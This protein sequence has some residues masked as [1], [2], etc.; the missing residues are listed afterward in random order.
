MMKK[1][2]FIC[3]VLGIIFV[4]F[5]MN[6]SAEAARTLRLA[7]LYPADFYVTQGYYRMAERIKAETNGE[8]EIQIFPANQLGSYEQAFEEVI[9][10]TIDMAGNYPTTRFNRRFEIGSFPG[11][12]KNFDEFRKMVSMDSPFSKLVKNVYEEAGCTYVGS[13]TAELMGAQIAKG[14]DIAEPFVARNKQRTVRVV[15]VASYRDFYR[16]MGYQITFVPYAEIFSSLQTGVIDGDVGSGPETVYLTNR[17]VVGSF[18][19]YN[20]I[21]ATNDL[22]INTKLWESFDDKTRDII[23]RAF[24]AEQDNV[25]RDARDSHDKYIEEMKTF[26]IKVV[27]PTPEESDYMAE[28][29]YEKIWP[30]YYDMFEKEVLDEIVEYVGK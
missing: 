4:G 29:A 14:K 3:M 1:K 28:L 20:N 22:V 18:I 12:V 13:F 30:K 17:D 2:L 10:G 7:S 26:G 23:E 15:A 6:N 25:Y 19:Q 27:D 16:E 5:A 11:L 21:A 8:I 24:E 9:R